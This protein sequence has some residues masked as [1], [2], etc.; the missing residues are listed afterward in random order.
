MVKSKSFSGFTKPREV[1]TTEVV[2]T[3]KV[4]EDYRTVVVFPTVAAGFIIVSLFV[5]ITFVYICN[6]MMLET[7][8]IDEGCKVSYGTTLTELSV[9]SY[10]IAAPSQTVGENN[11]ELDLEDLEDLEDNPY[12]S[13]YKSKGKLGSEFQLER[14]PKRSKMRGINN[15]HEIQSELKQGSRQLVYQSA[16]HPTSHPAKHPA[17]QS[18][19]Q[20]YEKDKESTEYIPSVIMNKQWN[21]KNIKQRQQESPPIK[22]FPATPEYRP[23]LKSKVI[24]PS[25]P[26]S[27]ASP[28][29]SVRSLRPNRSHQSVQAHQSVQS[30]QTVQSHQS[31]P[32]LRSNRSHQ[33]SRSL[34]S[35]RSHQSVPSFRTDRSLRTKRS[36]Q[37]VPSLRKDRSPLS[38][39]PS[40]SS[41]SPPS[42]PSHPSPSPSTRRPK[43]PVLNS[44]K[45]EQM[46]NHAGA[47]AKS[48][49]KRH[50]KAKKKP[51]HHKHGKI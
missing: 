39:Q 42:P 8:G 45:T 27:N 13:K 43:S 38:S 11:A 31:I 26:S 17:T 41:E 20:S 25:A 33:T 30:H 46:E 7:E 44:D 48:N 29:R 37:S 19:N 51:K 40:R 16:K 5:V 23:I 50:H 21:K 1:I 14:N 2:V 12:P 24:P 47:Q 3:E 18:I 22:I 6:R 9:L 34:P 28:A 35:D 10:S 32:S 36:H 15:V 4:E 49:R